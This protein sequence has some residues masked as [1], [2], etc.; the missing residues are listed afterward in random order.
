MPPY[1]VLWYS[2]QTVLVLSFTPGKL[3]VGK[4]SSLL[5][6]EQRPHDFKARSQTLNMQ[7]WFPT[8]TTSLCTWICEPNVESG[9]E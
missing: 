9:Q 5:I 2:K 4:W 3:R 6:Q 7:A 1:K 8:A